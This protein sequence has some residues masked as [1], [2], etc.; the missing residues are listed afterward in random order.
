MTNLDIK[1]QALKNTSYNLLAFGWPIIIAIIV[2]PIV[3]HYFGVKE[4]GI[5][6]FINTLISLAGLLDLGI[7]TALIKFIAECKGSQDKKGLK[8][9]FKTANS[10][11]VIIGAVGAI[12]II[13][14]IFIGIVSLPGEI[15]DSYKIY[16]PAFVY[17]GIL[18][19][20]TS[21]NNL[22][23]IVLNAYQRFDIGSKISIFFITIQQI[24]I[25]VTVFLN[26]SINTLF[27]IQVFI[28]FILYFM[29]K[30]YTG[31]IL[32]SHERS[33]LGVYGWNNV[34]AIKCYKFGLVSFVNNLASSSLTYF[35]RMIIPLFLGPSNLTFYSLPGSVTNKIPNLSSTLSSV[36]FPMTATFEGEG[37]R[38]MTQ[39]LYIRSMRLITII[40]TA[41]TVTFI[42]F[43]YQL[44]YFWIGPDLANKATGVFIVLAIT[45]LILAVMFPLN[46]LLLGMG[47]L[48]AL[49]ITSVFTAIINIFLLIILL[50]RFGIMGAAWAYLLALVP[51]VFLIYKTEKTYL[52]LTLRRAHY[53]KL[54]SQLFVT[55]V[56]VFLI[57][58][59]L[60]KPLIS[61]FFFVLIASV[62]SCLFFVYIHYSLG[63]FEKEDIDDI[64]NFIKKV[65]GVMKSKLLKN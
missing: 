49:S 39:N 22:H 34:E 32:N 40:S 18:F 37:N 51:Y 31:M 48:K 5:Y 21:I 7:S 45:N 61:N 15:S 43:A 19:F 24:S 65:T 38:T 17:A 64:F 1:E 44:L 26:W 53:I 4:Y 59:Y 60:M 11:L 23:I 29:Y 6:I 8:N 27:L 47:K 42:V 28:A 63:F 56:I 10:L 57:D 9:L 12:F 16:I 41:V 25:I 50:P 36:I 62:F 20:I 33:Y 13:S 58:F 52:E 46:N 14:S 30:K 54:L 55:S 2:T 3:V 35:D